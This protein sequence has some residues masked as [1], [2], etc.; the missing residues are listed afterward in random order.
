MR[1]L[2]AE[3]KYRNGVPSSKSAESHGPANSIFNIRIAT[4]F[5]NKAHSSLTIL[6]QNLIFRYLQ[7]VSL[8]ALS[9]LV[10]I[11]LSARNLGFRF[12]CM[13]EVKCA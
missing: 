13:E 11:T 5:L 1:I 2:A 4:V 6:W 10:L 8:I 12:G 7:N 9:Y 3:G